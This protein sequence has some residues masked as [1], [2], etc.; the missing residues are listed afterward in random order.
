MGFKSARCQD[1]SRG[2]KLARACATER[3]APCG[4]NRVIARRR[5]QPPSH[6]CGI[7]V[8][9]DLEGAARAV[10]GWRQHVLGL[11]YPSRTAR[12]SARPA[13][14]VWLF[15]WPRH[16]NSTVAVAP[17]DPYARG[18]RASGGIR[19]GRAHGHAAVCDGDARVW[20][21]VSSAQ[22]G[23]ICAERG[24]RCSSCSAPPLEG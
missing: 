13:R 14:V 23:N 21:A 6:V 9:T 4:V 11:R 20:R 24:G 16:T 8:V 18:K 12:S 22:R 17:L 7:G 19:E 3:L 5:R 10:A 2:L 15:V 1:E